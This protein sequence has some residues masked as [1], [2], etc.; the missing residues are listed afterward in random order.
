MIPP[1]FNVK[2]A[3][4]E[5]TPTAVS[6]IRKILADGSMPPKTRLDAAKLVLDAAAEAPAVEAFKIEVRKFSLTQEPGQ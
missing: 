1:N 5:L 4:R 3:L 6:V 2:E